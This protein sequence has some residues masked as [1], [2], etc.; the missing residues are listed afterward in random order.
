MKNIIEEF[1]QAD[2]IW[3]IWK[4]SDFKEYEKKFLIRGKFHRNVPE[5]IIKEYKTVERLLC[6]A[7]YHY[8]LLDEAFSKATRIF[9]ASINKRIEQ[10]S[11]NIPNGYVSL[12]KKIKKIK[13]FTSAALLD[14]WTKARKAR[15]IFAHPEAGRV[16]GITITRSF[17]QM[18]NIINTIFLDKEVIDENENKLENLKKEAEHLKNGLYKLNLNG[19]NIL[20]WSII[21]YSYFEVNK[22]EKSFWVFHPVFTYFPQT[23]QKL[24]FS[25]PIYLNLK[26]VTIHENGFSDL[27]LENNENIEAE[28]TDNILNVEAYKKHNDIV[29]SSDND[30]KQLYFIHLETELTYAVVKFLYSECWKN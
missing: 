22:I 27:N 3:S 25:L 11:L 29:Y 1:H 6:Y 17:Y 23:T 24:D 15:N 7:Y 13:P 21:P 16:F 26:D 5:E 10:L 2:P 4:S 18:I 14:E 12:E 8:P 30:V 20:I 28:T 9:E 19:K